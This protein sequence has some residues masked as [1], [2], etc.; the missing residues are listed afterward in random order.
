M[1]GAIA[2]G[3]AGAPPNWKTPAPVDADELFEVEPKLKPLLLFVEP[4]GF[5]GS[6]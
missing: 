5:E 1:V 6:V 2:G 3:A 4:N